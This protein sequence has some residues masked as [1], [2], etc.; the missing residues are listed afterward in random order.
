MGRLGVT[1]LPHHALS[2]DASCA[3]EGTMDRVR[4]ADDFAA[5]RAR[6]GE[7]RRQRE[8]AA[9][10]EAVEMDEHPS[11][12]RRWQIADERKAQVMVHKCWR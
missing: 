7:L 4:A 2:I 1:L 5:I 9:W 8:Q 3:G 6:M 11:A 12:A 10:R